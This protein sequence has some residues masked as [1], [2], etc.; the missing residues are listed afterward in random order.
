MGAQHAV[1]IPD[2][3]A[4]AE[5][6]VADEAVAV[7]PLKVQ[8]NVGCGPHPFPHEPGVRWINLDLDENALYP[9]NIEYVPG[10]ARNLPFETEK[11]DVVFSA[12]VI[13][14]FWPWEVHAAVKEWSR[15]IK[16]GGLLVLECPN[17]LSCMAMLMQAEY[18][19]DKRLRWFALNGIYGNPSEKTLPMKHKWGWTPETL[20]KLLEEC[21]LQDAVQVPAQFKQH[22]RDMR[23]IAVKK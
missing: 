3:G 6:P 16:L 12:H 14:H 19:D 1:P 5:A 18:S 4:I 15:V 20:C 21:G 8:L 23:V 13:E 9:S 10:D 22:N 7:Q 11:F 17:L 2:A